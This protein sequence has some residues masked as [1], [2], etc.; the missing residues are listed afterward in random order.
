MA[1]GLWLAAE[2]ITFLLV[3]SFFGLTGAVLLGLATSLIGFSLL[4]RLG[5]DGA[6]SLRRV[7]NRKGI[8]L[9]RESLVD[10]TLAAIG[11]VL[12]ILPGFLSDFI[13]LALSAPSI[14]FWLANRI[15]WPQ[16]AS[17][18]KTRPRRDGI[19][20]LDDREWRRIDDAKPD[21]SRS[22]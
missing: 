17:R 14:R 18:A 4:R 12:L 8:Q 10:G 11:G 16:K 21:F 22:V 5:K 9:Q 7:M 19:I 15:K 1:L 6:A 3:V 13:G 2:F 20:D